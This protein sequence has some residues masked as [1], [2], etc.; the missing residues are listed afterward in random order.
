MMSTF[1]FTVEIQLC[2]K[3]GKVSFQVSFNTKQAIENSIQLSQE[4]R[5][6]QSN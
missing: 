6:G 1:D 3:R 5:S 4:S 2:S